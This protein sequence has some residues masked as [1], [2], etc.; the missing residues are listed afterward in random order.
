MLGTV[1][2]IIGSIVAFITCSSGVNVGE[3]NKV[4]TSFSLQWAP[5]F[6]YTCASNE[7][8]IVVISA[9]DQDG[10]VFNWSGTVVISCTN[11]NISISPSSVDITNGSVQRSIAFTNGTL[12]NQGTG[13][14]LIS[15]EV[16][17]SLEAVVTI[18]ETFAPSDVNF[19]SAQAWDNQI[20]L[21]WTN[22]LDSDFA[23]V[24]IVRKEGEAPFNAGDGLKIYEGNNNAC[25]DKNLTNDVTYY[26]SAF[27][28]DNAPNYSGGKTINATPVD[29]SVQRLTY[30]PGNG[31]I[32]MYWDEVSTAD[33]YTLY[34]TNDGSDPGTGSGYQIT[35]ISGTSC[36]INNLS[37]FRKY[38]VALT[39]V[40]ESMESQKSNIVRIV[41]P[42]NIV[43]SGS[44][45]SLV[46]KEDGTVWAWGDN[47]YG[48]LGDGDIDVNK[49]TPVQVVWDDDQNPATDPIPF[50]NVIAISAGNRHSAAVLTDYTVWTWGSNVYYQLGDGGVVSERDLPGKVKNYTG[51]GELQDVIAVAAGRYHTVALKKDGTVWAWGYNNTGQLGDGRLGTNSKVP[52]Q[53]MWDHDQ[54]P[55]TNPEPFTNVISIAT[56]TDAQHTVALR[57]DGTVWAWG[58][59]DYGELGDGDTGTDKDLPVQVFGLTDIVAVDADGDSG[60]RAHSAALKSDGTVWTWGSNDYGQLGDGNSGVDSDLPV[61]V[62]WD[63]DGNPATDPVPL[64]N[65]IAIGTGGTFTV[66]VKDDD[67]TWAWGYNTYGELGDGNSGVNSDLPVQVVWDDDGNPATDTVPFKNVIALDAGESH[68]VAIAN[69]GRLWAWGTNFSGELGDGNNPVSSDTSVLVSVAGGS[70]SLTDVIE[71]AMKRNHTVALKSDG[72]VWTWG[73]NKDG[74]LGNNNAGVDS[75]VPVEVKSNIGSRTMESVA[76]GSYHSLAIEDNGNLWAWGDNAGGQLGAGDNLDHAAPFLVKDPGGTSYLDYVVA[77]DGG[78]YHTLAARDNGVDKTVYAWGSNQY[79]QIGHNAGGTDMNRPQQVVGPG[80]VGFLLNAK[81]V[82]AGGVHSV[83]LLTGGTVYAWGRNNF[84]QLGNGDMGSVTGSDTPIQVVWDHDGNAGTAPI[85]FTNVNT[86]AAGLYH[87]VALRDDGTVWAWGSNDNG[88]LGDNN[89]GT[90]SDLPRQVVGP[91]GIGYLTGIVAI[92]AGSYH[93]VAL[94]DDGTV[95]AW[96]NDG[97]GCLGN[98]DLT[99]NYDTPVQVVDET[100]L[101]YITDV[102]GIAAGNYNTAA[103]KNDGMVSSWGGNAIGQLGNGEFGSS[104]NI[105]VFTGVFFTGWRK[106]G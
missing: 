52:V 14:K 35:G 33:S 23:G 62:V 84:G 9:H 71:I 96:G 51:T 63:D 21:S 15:G 104:S 26:Y 79:G 85:G 88:E 61:Q 68:T 24:R 106:K 65:G 81:G 57:D 49:P 36:E 45:F 87:T 92:K 77:V 50:V 86:I 39:A 46:L 91:E 13:I 90:N 37:N 82:A 55:A 8:V 56:G 67:T 69:S 20:K 54:N 16:V 3:A 60:L 41:P 64:E 17:Q 59:N 47:N 40:K 83:A 102:K 70:E 75:A 7:P 58:R 22:P 94:K 4:L 25:V 31:K 1:L 6:D 43:A 74:Q 99:G 44:W 27:A 12:N 105:P 66:V 11:P 18:Y 28:Y 89:M 32:T 10:E 30:L 53:V 73:Y 2:L 19:F 29:R 80:G 97:N 103:L 100:G 48:A 72:K 5:G 76:A 42:G 34:Y 98:G 95:W 101:N 78:I 93:T 38:K